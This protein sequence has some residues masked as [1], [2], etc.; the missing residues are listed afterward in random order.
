MI[1]LIYVYSFLFIPIIKIT[2]IQK[3]TMTVVLIMKCIRLVAVSTGNAF[4]KQMHI[5]KAVAV[6]IIHSCRK[7]F[8]GNVY[9]MYEC[10][11]SAI[12]T[13]ALNIIFK[14]KIHSG[15]KPILRKKYEA[16]KFVR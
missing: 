1:P 2:A 14:I 16:K 15:W 6:L 3:I 8:T 11:S 12:T 5:I 7:V 4:I 13:N 9:L 10:Q